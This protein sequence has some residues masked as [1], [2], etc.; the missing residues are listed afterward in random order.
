MKKLLLVLLSLTLCLT[1]L[2]ACTKEEATA[3]RLGGLKGPTTMGMVKLLKDAQDGTAENEY[4]FTLAASADELTP[5]LLKGELD[6]LAVPANLGAVLFNNS[7]GAVQVLAINTLGVVYLVENGNTL[8]SLE[9]LRG[10]TIYATGKGSTPEA[11]L[12]YILTQ[13]GIDP[14]KDL[15]IEWKSEPAEVVAIM[16]Q[17]PDTIAMLPQPFVTAAQNTVENLRIAVDLTQAWDALDNGSTL[18]TGVAIV[19]TEFAKEHPRA[20]AT[21]LKEYEAST[22][23]VNANVADAAQLIG[24]L[25]IVKAPIAEKAIPYCNIT[26]I[27]GSELKPVLSGY[28]QVLFDQNSKSVGGKLP[29]DDFY[30]VA[31]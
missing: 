6:I 31:K 2:A 30:Y 14:E 19:R 3:I 25:D 17:T 8:Q 26:Y 9:D 10:K 13:N 22:Q 23:Y 24:D 16:S 5:K 7:E 11:A 18:V 1:L 21:F 4:D 20:V 28:L 27:G 29:G 15:T 12:N